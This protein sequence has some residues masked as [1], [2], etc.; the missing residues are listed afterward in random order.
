[1]IAN[2]G[3]RTRLPDARS[4][5]SWLALHARSDAAKDIEILMLRQEVAVLRRTN[6]RP[7]LTWLDRAV[8]SPLSRLLPPPAAP[9]AAGLARTLLR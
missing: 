4:R 8:L 3:L 2:C 5:L 7:I 9:A 6:S 1:M